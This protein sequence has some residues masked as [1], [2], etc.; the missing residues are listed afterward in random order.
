MKTTLFYTLIG[1]V[2]YSLIVT[3]L[4][5]IAQSNNDCI[6][7]ENSYLKEMNDIVT[8]YA[9]STADTGEFDEFIHSEAGQDY[10]KLNKDLYGEE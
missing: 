1:V 2:I 3:I 7:F 4:L 9:D 6:K 10:F 5:F 8:N